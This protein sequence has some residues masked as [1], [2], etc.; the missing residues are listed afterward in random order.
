MCFAVVDIFRLN[1]K[2]KLLKLLKRNHQAQDKGKETQKKNQR[3][4]VRYF[5]TQYQSEITF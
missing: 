2:W 3:L 5:N 1:V 4:F